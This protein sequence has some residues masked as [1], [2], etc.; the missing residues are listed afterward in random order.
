MP[1]YKRECGEAFVKFLNFIWNKFDIWF[2]EYMNINGQKRV[3]PDQ[4]NPVESK[5]W[6]TTDRTIKLGKPKNYIICLLNDLVKRVLGML[7]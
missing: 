6:Y 1:E 7:S 3:G 5:D 4:G 2:S